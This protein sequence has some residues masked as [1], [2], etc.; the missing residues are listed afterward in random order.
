MRCERTYSNRVFYKEDFKW[1]EVPTHLDAIWKKKMWQD[2][3]RRR[4]MMK[5]D[6]LVLSLKSNITR[7][8]SWRSAN[9]EEAFKAD[10]RKHKTKVICKIMVM[11]GI[12]GIK[13]K[14][15]FQVSIRRFLQ[16]SARTLRSH[17]MPST[18]FQKG[19]ADLYFQ[20]KSRHLASKKEHTFLLFNGAFRLQGPC[21]LNIRPETTCCIEFRASVQDLL[22]CTRASCLQ[23][24]LSLTKMKTAT[25]YFLIIQIM[26]IISQWQKWQKTWSSQLIEIMETWS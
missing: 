14:A 21:L 7:D 22:L 6:V 13:S 3:S 16:N 4:L 24:H 8:T 25:E 10:T 2:G 19:R 12:G 18:R 26:Q 20:R 15:S 1:S 5:D 11:P 17:Q 9:L 23:G